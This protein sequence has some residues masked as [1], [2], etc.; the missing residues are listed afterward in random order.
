MSRLSAS[1]FDFFASEQ[2]RHAKMYE[3][4]PVPKTALPP[5]WRM[6][7]VELARPWRGFNVC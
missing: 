1:G 3:H 4:R 5:S 6:D 2:V 7:S